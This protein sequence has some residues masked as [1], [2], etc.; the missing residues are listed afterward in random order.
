L[1]LGVPTPTLFSYRCIGSNLAEFRITAILQQRDEYLSPKELRQEVSEQ[2]AQWYC[3]TKDWAGEVSCEP[4][5]LA[6][7]LVVNGNSPLTLCRY[8][9]DRS[10]QP[11]VTFHPA[12]LPN[13]DPS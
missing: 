1:S 3:G 7:C 4:T 6:R 5:L 10:A 2:Q 13:L 8:P 9:S 11:A 12:R